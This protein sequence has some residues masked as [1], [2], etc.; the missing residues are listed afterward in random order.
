MTPNATFIDDVQEPPTTVLESGRPPSVGLGAWV[1]RLLA[2]NAVSGSN[3]ERYGAP[4]DETDIDAAARECWVALLTPIGPYR[5]RR[6]EAE[7]FREI[8]RVALMLSEGW[9]AWEHYGLRR[10]RKEVGESMGLTVRQ[11]RSREALLQRAIDYF[12]LGWQVEPA[13]RGRPSGRGWKP[14]TG[15][16]PL[17]RVAARLGFSERTL[18]RHLYESETIDIDV[19]DRAVC[20]EGSITVRDLYPDLDDDTPT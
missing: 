13:F 10:T 7:R 5:G 19:V 4:L 16:G 11:L 18:Y 3:R 17:G 15:R 8:D 9:L 6:R 1:L 2:Q 12:R 14:A 20:N